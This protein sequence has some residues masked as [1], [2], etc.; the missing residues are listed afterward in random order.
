MSSGLTCCPC[1]LKQLHNF[2]P[3]DYESLQ[4]ELTL[5]APLWR[6]VSSTESHEDSS[7]TVVYR[8]D[9]VTKWSAQQAPPPWK[10]NNIFIHRYK[11]HKGLFIACVRS[12][13]CLGKFRAFLCFYVGAECCWDF[14][15]HL[16]VALVCVWAGWEG[17]CT[18]YRL[19]YLDFSLSGWMLF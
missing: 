9:T 7:T 14:H 15:H 16:F 17:S 13:Y 6:K 3:M 18:V 8:M 12:G 1:R 11:W 10:K 19:F 5:K 2:G 4:R